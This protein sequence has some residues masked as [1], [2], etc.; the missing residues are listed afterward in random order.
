MTSTST[1][2]PQ[3]LHVVIPVFNDWEAL[4]LL[5]E[6]IRQSVAEPLRNC[7]AFLIVDDCSTSNFAALPVGVGQSLSVMRLYRNVGH[8]KA[9]S[10]GLSYL[11]DQPVQNP[12]VVMDG[13]GEDCPEDIEQLLQTAAQQPG[14]IVFARRSK[15]QESLTFK[16]FY[17]IYKRVFQLLTGKVITF[18]NFSYVPAEVVKKLVRVSEIWNHYPGGIIRSRLPYTATPIA[19][20]TRLAGTSKM[21]FVSLAL[22]GLSAVAVLI[23][24]TAV[25]IA[26]FCILTALVSVVGIGMVFGLRFF[27]GTSVS[28]WMIYLL[29]SFFILIMQAFLVSLLLVFVVL[30]YRTQN[31][32]IPAFQYRQFVETVEVVY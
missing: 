32:F 3:T 17:N 10:L 7:L 6:R 11:A 1:S 20:G 21:N 12:V 31:H 5:L 22:H 15:R 19:R 28:N 13:D 18:G 16:L 27:A 9:I 2:Y 4:G 24:T 26:V 14:R 29:F 30:T 25:R 23:D 8:Q